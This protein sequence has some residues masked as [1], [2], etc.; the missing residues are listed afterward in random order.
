MKLEFALLI[1]ESNPLVHTL[2]KIFTGD[3]M[4]LW[5]VKC[6]TNLPMPTST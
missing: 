6:A 3:P 4:A 5:A 2:I 1:H